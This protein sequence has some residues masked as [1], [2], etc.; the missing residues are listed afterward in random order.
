LIVPSARQDTVPGSPDLATGPAPLPAHLIPLPGGDWA[1]W[2]C[3]LLR[4]AGFPAAGVLGLAAPAAAAAAER[5]LDREEAAE[6]ARA[7]ALRAVHAALDGLRRA[8][9]WDERERRRPLM[10]A[11]QALAAGKLPRELAEPGCAAAFAALR[12]AGESLAEA[13]AELAR[14]FPGEVARAS[15]EIARVAADE[16]FREAILWQNRHACATALDRL[17]RKPADTT[18]RTSQRRQHEELVAGYLQRY[19]VMNDTIG[20]FGPVGFAE[21][22]DGGGPAA[23]RYG[24]DLLARREV[25]FEAWCIDRLAE[26]LTGEPAY[27]PWLAPRL[28]SSF[29]LAGDLLYRSFGQPVRLSPQ[30]AR[31]LA[32]C[33]EQQSAAVLARELVADPAAPFATE[34]EVFSLLETLARTRVITWDS[35]VP[36]DLH[37][38]RRL[39]ERLGQIED[40]RLR[41]AALS[42]LAELRRARA[43]VA[44]AA[45]EARALDAALRDLEGTFVRLTRMAPRRLAGQMY[46]G[47]G[48]VY[49]DCRRDVE[50][51]FGAELLARL[52]PPLSRLLDAARWVAGELARSVEEILRPIHAEF[53]GRSGDGTVASHDLFASGMSILYRQ[54]REPSFV[55]V[56]REYHAR[57]ARAVGPVADGA[58]SIRLTA[59]ELA[60]RL[61]PFGD[62]GTAW[63]LARY[64]SP[65]VM[66]VASDLAAFQRGDF[67]LVLGEVHSG[68][69]LLWSCFLSQ[70]PEPGRIAAALAAD[71]GGETVVLPRLHQH[72]LVQRLNLGVDLPWIYHFELADTPVSAPPAQILPAGE[73]VI[74]DTP[75]GLL[76]RTRDGRV[77]FPAIDLFTSCLIQECSS[78]LGAVLPPARHTPRLTVDHLVISRERWRFTA[79]ELSFAA[80]Q[81]PLDRFL[82]F[83]RWARDLGLPRFCFYKISTER[84]PCYL[85][86]TSPIYVDTFAR[87]LRTARESAQGAASVA[88][89]EMLPRI[90]QTWLGDAAGNCYT[91]ELRIA[92]LRS[93]PA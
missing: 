45:G 34:E 6:G 46:A 76:A 50:V 80:V 10:K 31:L 40:T 7:D 57:W 84:K 79:D 91:S 86:L 3:L 28:K 60:E 89:T 62:S 43:G 26:A 5:V 85:D 88:V 87:L 35:G 92:A 52:G 11:M 73:V 48:L 44:A 63:T 27:R 47:R 42:R 75:V 2:R 4:G 41:D 1:L 49:E 81:D 24:A 55:A 90:D 23:V 16:R 66:V 29:H 93:T 78:I 58:R 13:R 71:S 18:A 37:P 17:V 19:C 14:V 51:R 65:D 69:T 12:A 21:L 54:E 82:A 83:R 74:A 9:Q 70:H 38:D 64:F 59:A 20:F 39:A 33:R 77:S 32:G 8:G 36:L 72:A 68:N 25:Y 30:V 15:A 61:T 67:E 56:E 53:A 22:T